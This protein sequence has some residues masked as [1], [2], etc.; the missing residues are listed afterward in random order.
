MKTRTGWLYP[1]VIFTLL[2]GAVALRLA[3]PFVV[4]ALRL[5]A[6]DSYQRLAPETYN[7]ALPVRVVDI[8]E[9]SLAKIGQWPWPRTVIAELLGRLSDQG[10]SVVIFDV[11][12]AE[13]DQTSPG[14]AIVPNLGA[15]RPVLV[16]SD[17]RNGSHDKMF[18]E[19]IADSNVVLSTALTN[20]QSEIPP[21][22]AGFS[23]AGDDPR[24]FIVG[25]AG[26]SRNLPILDAATDGIGSINWIPDRDQV[27]RRVPLVLRVGEDLVPSLALEALRVNEDA[28][29]YVLKSSNAN[30]ETAFGGQTGLNHIKVG[31]IEIPTDAD[32]GIWL[33][34]RPSNPGAYLPAWE[35]LTGASE[36]GEINGRMMLIGTS[37]PGLVDLRATSLDSAIAG[38]EVHAQA[39]EHILS[40][41]SLT[42]PDYS[43]AAELAVI[44]VLG[45]LLSIIFTRISAIFSALLGASTIAGILYSGWYAYSEM[46]L[47]FDPSFP[48]LSLLIFVSVA[49]F[50]IYRRVELQ[51]AEMRGAF[52]HYV[53][54]AV[55]DEIIAHPDRLELGGEVRDLTLLFCDVRN[56]TSISEQLNAR[57]LTRFLN[58]LL[59]PLS[60]IILQNRGTIDKY[61]G[62][63]IMAFWNAPLDD[64]N[65]A[66]NACRSANEM[67][68]RMGKLNRQWRAEAE[69]AG[70][71]FIP[72]SIGI[73]INSGEC[74]VGNLGSDQR[75]DYSAIGDQVNVASRLEGQSKLYG[76]PVVVGEATV[77]HHPEVGFLELDLVKV[78]GRTSSTRIYTL[79]DSL[80]AKPETIERLEPLHRSMLEAYRGRDW[81]RAQMLLA[82]CRHVGVDMLKTFYEIYSVRVGVSR[83]DP[84]PDDWDGAYIADSE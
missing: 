36:A 3:D 63:A 19:A 5:V 30:G 6:F 18:A 44:I 46:G 40:G 83:E 33:N 64:A 75:F 4:Q 70:R 74:L 37:A 71:P 17:G 29:G 41:R 60:N 2:A 57:E 20:R 67:M 43:L 34:F 52:G 79:A 84:P 28:K 32:G 10:A 69:K 76:V 24:P 35:V 59:T 39:I 58:N 7:P 22:K 45:L 38:V 80:G 81:N 15:D 78:R 8:D 42:R 66:Q 25:F 82:E 13:S 73:G 50:Y 26:A 27:I 16:A 54:P 47:L 11:L 61:M 31:D 77:Q 65:H 9:E 49:T 21:A 56:F 23:V 62:D 48:A 12:F 68:A 14:Q 1:I 72:V 53:S 51:R 55:V